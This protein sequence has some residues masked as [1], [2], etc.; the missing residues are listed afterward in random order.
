MS[1][2]YF[3]TIRTVSLNLKTTFP[4]GFR[5]FFILSYKSFGL[6]HQSI[7]DLKTFNISNLFKQNLFTSTLWSKICQFSACTYEKS[8]NF[9]R[10]CRRKQCDA[11]RR[12]G[13]VL[14]DP[15]TIAFKHISIVDKYRKPTNSVVCK[16]AIIQM[17]Y[18]MCKSRTQL[19]KSFSFDCAV[20]ISSAVLRYSV[21]KMYYIEALKQ[22]HRNCAI[23]DR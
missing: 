11:T 15:K 19:N 5:K 20:G 2:N 21:Y 13:H 8:A 9:V 18:W 22:Q 3:C 4:Q 23:I 6:Y 1:F 16:S 14:R 17:G 7:F 10:L 12:H